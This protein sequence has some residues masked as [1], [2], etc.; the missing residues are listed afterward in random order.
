NRCGVY[1]TR[2]RICRKYTTDNCEWHGGE[3]DYDHLFTSAEQLRRHAEDV[4]G[5]PLVKK[6]KPKKPKRR[7]GKNGKPAITLP[8]T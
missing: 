3:Y 8:V 2:P 4:L 7:V 5:K 6:E 1:E